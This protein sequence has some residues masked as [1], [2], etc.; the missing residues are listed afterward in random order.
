MV[1]FD[2]LWKIG[3]PAVP[4]LQFKRSTVYIQ[5]LPDLFA[6][7]RELEQQLAEMRNRVDSVK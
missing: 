4:H 1:G 5:R 2:A 7:V 6:K 3:A